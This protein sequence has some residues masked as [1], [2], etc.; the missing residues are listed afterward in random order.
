MAYQLI[1]NLNFIKLKALKNAILYINF[2][3]KINFKKFFFLNKKKK[4][5][6]LKRF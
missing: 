6:E 4:V 3:M 5:T 2:E 1:K